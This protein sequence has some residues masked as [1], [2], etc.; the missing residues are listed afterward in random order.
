M[1]CSKLL[2]VG[3]L[4]FLVLFSA[5]DK[6]DEEENVNAQDTNFVAAASLSNRAE[7]DLGNLA[8]TKAAHDSVRYFAQQMITQHTQ[9]QQDLEETV[10]DIDLNVDLNQAFPAEVT[11]MRQM[12]AGLNGAAFDSVYMRTQVQS[13][14][15]TLA[16]FQAELSAGIN[17]RIRSYATEYQ[18][19]IQMH[20]NMAQRIHNQVK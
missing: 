16:A 9:A 11:Q 20:L 14:Q 12:L 7:V 1:K 13:H 2:S 5:C 15:L 17:N 3:A 8:L 19:H 6:D 4:S 18:P 10:D